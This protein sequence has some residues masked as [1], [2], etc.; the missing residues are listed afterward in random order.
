MSDVDVGFNSMVSLPNIDMDEYKSLSFQILDDF[1]DNLL[2]LGSKEVP[3]ETVAY[4]AQH[5][6]L[7]T[8]LIDFSYDPKVALYFAC[9]EMEGDDCSVYMFDI[10]ARVKEMMDIYESGRVGFLRNPDRTIMNATEREMHAKNMCT[11]LDRNGLSTVTPIINFGDIKYAQRILNQKGAFIYH[12]DAVPMDQLMYTASTHTDYQGRRVY[13]IASALKADILK[14]LDEEYG[15][16][17]QFIYP[18]VELN[19]NIIET[20]VQKT[21]VKFG[22]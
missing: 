9:C 18:N 12:R 3:F 1:Y 17:K 15:I 7:P 16:N 19:L 22:L 11:T 13:K 14:K 6:G 4:L 8:D 21:K 20:A 10:Y 2:N 5:Y